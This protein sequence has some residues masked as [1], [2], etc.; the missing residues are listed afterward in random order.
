M[1]T[2]SRI[3]AALRLLDSCSKGAVTGASILVDGGRV[4]YAAK[5]D[6]TCVFTDLPPTP[7]TYEISAP[8]YCPV[9][10]DLP[11]VPPHLPEVVLMQHAP[12]TPALSRISCFRLRFLEG[13][14]PLGNARVRAA[15]RTPVGGLRLVEEARRGE[16]T[17]ALA[18]AYALG[19]LYQRY[20]VPY[21]SEETVLITGYDRSAGRYELQDPLETPLERGA[22]LA[23]VWDLVTDRDG[24]AVLPAIGLFL[25]REEAELAFAWNGKEQ[26]VSTPPPSPQCSFTV[27]F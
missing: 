12:G 22:L 21:A 14:R 26:R 11:V 20:R 19:M 10:L 27:V 4:R 7:H 5:G 18:G 2:I 24:A 23:P 17:L 6:G 1:R 13:E 9:R 25:Q 8:G 15:L 3:S 16:D